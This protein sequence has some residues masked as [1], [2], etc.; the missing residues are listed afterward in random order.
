MISALDQAMHLPAKS[1]HQ[2]A[3]SL[4][5]DRQS[6]FFDT[7]QQASSSSYDKAPKSSQSPE[8]NPAPTPRRDVPHRTEARRSEGQA[9]IQTTH[10]RTHTQADETQ[11]GKQTKLAGR[12]E[13]AEHPQPQ[14]QETKRDEEILAVTGNVPA[15]PPVQEALISQGNQENEGSLNGFA[16]PNLGSQAST[17]IQN[18]GSLNGFA[19]PN[20]GSQASTAIQN[21]GSLNG[22]AHPN[23]GSQASTAIQNEGSLNGFAHP[24]L[25]SQ[26]STVIQNEE[27]TS[28]FGSTA[29]AE[30]T[31]LGKELAVQAKQPPNAQQSATEKTLLG[32]E[33]AVQAN[34][35]NQEPQTFAKSA[36][37]NAEQPFNAQQPATEKTLLGKEL[38]VQANLAGKVR[39]EEGSKEAQ[40]KLVQTLNLASSET[41]A[42]D[43]R[44]DIHSPTPAKGSS[45]SANHSAIVAGNTVSTPGQEVSNQ[46]AFLMQQNQKGPMGNPLPN[47]GLDLTNDTD[48]QSSMRFDATLGQTMASSAANQATNLGQTTTEVNPRA[49]LDQVAHQARWMLSNTRKEVSMQLT[50]EH[51]GRLNMKIS[52]QEGALSIEMIVENAS[53]KALLESQQQDLRTRL[54]SIQDIEQFELQ[55]NVRQENHAKEFGQQQAGDQRQGN[56]TAQGRN[57]NNPQ[58][59][60]E[61][62]GSTNQTTLRDENLNGVSIFA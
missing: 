49:M 46:S 34:P 12:T 18:E 43:S 6:A 11:H 45:S 17:A 36:F 19:H 29:Q 31:L 25:G 20:L 59:A 47:Q 32:K 28:A 54:A 9:H 21:E 2:A 40:T 33:L 13:L 62:L 27:A 22:F 35:A 52:Q 58:A 24:N 10:A 48:N 15:H 37:L 4:G 30:K 38:A 8:H 39:N 1:A 51:L 14:E 16:Y 55:V 23:L 61:G 41:K 60:N 50:P 26:A 57:N 7:L 3:I 5:E 42:K 56:S 53:T 44:S